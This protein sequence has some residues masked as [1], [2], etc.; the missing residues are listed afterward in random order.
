MKKRISLL[1]SFVLVYVG[2]LFSQNVGINFNGAAPNSSAAFDIN[3]SAMEGQ[4]K[5]LLI[6]RVTE[7]QRLAMNPLPV[8]AKGLMVFQTDMQDGFYYNNSDALAPMWI[9]LPGTN[10]L[11]WDLLKNAANPLN[12]QNGGNASFIRYDGITSQS[13]FSLASNSLTT[14]RVLDI[15][16]T[17]TKG[18][19]ANN[20]YIANFSK[21]GANENASHT[22]WGIRSSVSNTGTNSTNYAAYFESTGG[23]SNYAIV[24]PANGGRVSIGSTVSSP[25]AALAISNGHFQSQQT[26]P[27][28]IAANANAGI[29]ASG[30]LSIFSS[31][32]AGNFI[33]QTGGGNVFS[34]GP[35]AIITFAIPYIRIPK[36]I[37]TP[38]NE[39][40][41]N[42]NYFVTTNASS[43][44]VHFTTAPT[45]GASYSFNYIAITN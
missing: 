33:I 24:V 14:G 35:Q 26:I 45:A 23:A 7:A 25:N 37:L 12:L 30:S 5:G 41:A 43:F 19:G 2:C 10:N 40:A 44:T 11:R 18:A 32:M 20:S 9:F 17:S 1:L 28:S 29:L 31:D 8:S 15:S 3:V 16:S 21:S 36:V 39:N 4:K 6:P 34:S 27:P 42:K 22:S 38:A 13:G